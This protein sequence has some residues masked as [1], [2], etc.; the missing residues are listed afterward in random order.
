MQECDRINGD[1]FCGETNGSGTVPGC[2]LSS[3]ASPAP[4]IC[5]GLTRGGGVETKEYAQ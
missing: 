2:F 4:C 3:S 5:G 1:V